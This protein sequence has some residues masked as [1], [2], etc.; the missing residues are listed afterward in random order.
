MKIAI[1]GAGINGLYLAWQLSKAGHRVTVFEKKERIGKEACSGLFSERILEFIPESRKLIQNEIKSALIRFPKKTLEICFSKKF[2]VMSHFELDNLVAGLARAA[3]AK[4]ILNQTINSLP[5]GFDRI[6]GCDGPLSTVR[7]KLNSTEGDYRLAIQGFIDK[8]DNSNFVET[9]PIKSG[10]LW[11]IPRGKEV[12]YGIIGEAK[13]V[14]DAFDGFLKKENI[15]VGR[16]KSALVPRN[17]CIPSNPKITLCGDAAGLTKPWSGGGVV[18]GLI[19]AGILLKNFPDF[20]KYQK[21]ARSFFLPRIVFSRICTVGAYFFGLHSP[22]LLP[23]KIKI[24][25]D[26]LL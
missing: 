23:T 2:F 12:E 20:L 14:K 19:A 4:I 18:W 16:M 21:K 8:E 11:R 26:F 17:F 10:F 22:W 15:Q 25:S 6:I 24:E 5:E 9:W 7:K 13:K 1:V 3:G